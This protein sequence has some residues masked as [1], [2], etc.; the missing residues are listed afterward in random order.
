[1]GKDMDECVYCQ[2]LCGN[3]FSVFFFLL[4][5][6]TAA[7]ENKMNEIDWL[8]FARIT[9]AVS[10]YN[11]GRWRYI[12]VFCSPILFSLFFLRRH[13]TT[14][15]CIDD[16]KV[17]KVRTNDPFLVEFSD[18]FSLVRFIFRQH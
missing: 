2:I 15:G 6:G 13:Q 16:V 5:F 3:V 18:I 1:M 10:E 9:G 14:K 7:T 11:L 8:F 12:F 4:I 17:R